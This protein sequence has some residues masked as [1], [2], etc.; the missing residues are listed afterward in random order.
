MGFDISRRRWGARVGSTA[1]V[2]AMGMIANACGGGGSALACDR[3]P[4]QAETFVLLHGSWHGGWCWGK[5]RQRLQG[6]GFDTLAP[7][8]TGMSERTRYGSLDTGLVAHIDEV[9]TML[10][11]LDL[12]D[13]VLVGHSYAGIVLSGVAERAA[14]RI[15]RLVYLDA[16]ALRDGES[17]F[18]FFPPDVRDLFIALAQGG[19]GWGVPPP[20]TAAD[21]FLGPVGGT[22]SGRAEDRAFLQ[23]R[24]TLLPISTH[25]QALSI[26]SGAAQALPRTYIS[27]TRFPNLDE[28][29]ARVRQ[30]TGW[31]YREIDTYH[32]CM[33]TAPDALTTLL[34]EAAA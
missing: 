33:L 26:P 31:T 18:S 9:A 6:R 3:F 27:C 22:G 11:A 12:T 7:T 1:A 8:F 19:N 24:L 16:F 10:D 5:V 20:P 14:A 2:G 23:A 28:N 17:A 4:S 29:K 21:D 13:V 32:D 25:S 30:E 34:V 15:K